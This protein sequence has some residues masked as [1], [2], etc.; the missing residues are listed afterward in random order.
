MELGWNS[1]LSTYSSVFLGRLLNS[2]LECLFFN[3][4]YTNSIY[5]SSAVSIKLEHIPKGPAKVQ[6]SV[7]HKEDSKNL[8][9]VSSPTVEYKL[10]IL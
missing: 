3:L 4:Q 9:L 10:Q 6:Q 2:V 5:F 8:F 1:N 7:W